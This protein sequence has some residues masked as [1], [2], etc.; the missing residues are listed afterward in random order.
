MGGVKSLMSTT[1]PSNQSN[2][3]FING[4]PSNAPY[5][6]PSSFAQSNSNNNSLVAS[7]SQQN[8]QQQ[9]QQ[10]PMHLLLVTPELRPLHMDALRRNDDL[11]D[12]LQMTVNDL[13]QWLEVFEAGIKNVRST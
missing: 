12:E 1:S 8:L 7:N 4:V 5:L 3:H 9:L 11:L 2:D 6:A 10:V 13:S